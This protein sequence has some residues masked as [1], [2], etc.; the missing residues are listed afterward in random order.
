MVYRYCKHLNYINI[1]DMTKGNYL[2]RPA[3]SRWCANKDIKIVNTFAELMCLVR[4]SVI[5]LRSC[6]MTLIRHWDRTQ[7]HWIYHL[8]CV[9]DRKIILPL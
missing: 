8:L 4:I 3:W 6:G 7:T 1:K 5:P 2:V 9:R